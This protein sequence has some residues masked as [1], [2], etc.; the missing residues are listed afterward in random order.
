MFILQESHLISSQ[1]V[2]LAASG[3]LVVENSSGAR[4][5]ILVSLFDSTYRLA[6][7]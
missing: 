1:T 3:P 2:K 7:T 5:I 6:M 4:F